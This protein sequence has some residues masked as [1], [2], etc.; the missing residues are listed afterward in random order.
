VVV[1]SR[2]ALHIKTLE[3]DFLISGL[4]ETPLVPMLLGDNPIA[5]QEKEKIVLK[6]AFLFLFKLSTL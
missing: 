4:R 3:Q 1:E 6:Y 5:K 2:G